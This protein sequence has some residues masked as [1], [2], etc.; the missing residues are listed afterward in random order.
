[1]PDDYYGETIKA[2]VTL[3]PGKASTED[4]LLDFCAVNLA[5]YKVPKSIVIAE[6]I[7]KTTVGKID[8][9]AL[10]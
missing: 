2:W 1:V 10:R 8:K 7:P 4:E 3:K 9:K 5:K 6:T